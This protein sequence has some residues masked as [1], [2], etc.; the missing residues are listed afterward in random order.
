MIVFRFIFSSLILR[1]LCVMFGATPNKQN[2]ERIKNL[3]QHFRSASRAF[4]DALDN[5]VS[6]P[7]G[8]ARRLVRDERLQRVSN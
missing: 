5:I 1:L 4:R 3:I 7:Q 8:V 2:A 6:Y